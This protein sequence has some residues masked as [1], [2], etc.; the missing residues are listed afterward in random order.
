MPKTAEHAIEALAG[1]LDKLSQ[2]N[3]DFEYTAQ[4]SPKLLRDMGAEVFGETLT[5]Y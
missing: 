2:Q 3:P 1:A 5:T 4:A